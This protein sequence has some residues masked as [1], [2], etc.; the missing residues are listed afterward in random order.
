M[1]VERNK[2]KIRS[3]PIVIRNRHSV[4]RLNLEIFGRS[5]LPGNKR[6]GNCDIVEGNDRGK[7]RRKQ[8]AKKQGFYL[9]RWARSRFRTAAYRLW[10]SWLPTPWFSPAAAKST[11][12]RMKSAVCKAEPIRLN[13]NETKFDRG[14]YLESTPVFLACLGK[15]CNRL[16]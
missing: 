7:G 11:R 14:K 10:K 5:P 16:H 6:R 8:A 13:I 12:T 9:S 2:S 15:L 4:Q 3:D 1:D